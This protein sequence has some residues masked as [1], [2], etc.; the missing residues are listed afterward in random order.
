MFRIVNH[1]SLMTVK[2]MMISPK[3]MDLLFLNLETTFDVSIRRTDQDVEELI[4]ALI[5]R[6]VQ[7][8]QTFYS[9]V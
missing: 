5:L 7:S 8:S 6:Q 3:K 1:L 2:V 9:H 4:V